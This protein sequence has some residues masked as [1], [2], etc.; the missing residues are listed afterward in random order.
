MAKVVTENFKVETTNELYGSFL[1]ENENAVESF[2]ESLEAYTAINNTGF[3]YYSY[4]VGATSTTFATS[5]NIHSEVIVVSG[6]TLLSPTSTPPDYTFTQSTGAIVLATGVTG[7]TVKI[8]GLNSTLSESTRDDITTL[9]RKEINQFLP[10]NNYYVM[11]SSIDKTNDILNSQFEKR[12][13]LRRVIFA[14]KIDVSNIKYMFNRIPWD[15]SGTTVYDAFDDI[16]DIETLNMFVT[17]PDGEQNEGPYKVFKCISNNNNSV[18]INKPSVNSIDPEYE[19]TLA[20]GYIWKYMFNIPVSEYA[21]YSTQA[22]LPYVEDVRVT[23]ATKEDISNIVIQNT[24]SGL[25]SGYLPGI[26]KIQ[27]VRIAPGDNRYEIDCT[28][29]E[30]SPRSGSGAYV[31]MYIRSDTGYLYDI[32]DSSVPNNDP[33]NRNLVITI[34]SEDINGNL[35]VLPDENGDTGIDVDRNATIVPKISITSSNDVETGINAVA[36]GS[37]DAN[38][39][40]EKVNFNEKGDGYKYATAKISLPLPLQQTYPDSSLAASLRVI[41]SPTGGHGKDPI[42]ELF[43]SRLAFITNFFTDSGSVIPDSGTYTKVGL[44]KDPSFSD[45]TFRSTMDNR[46]KI[47]ITG[48]T[49]PNVT[50]GQY[51]V[52]QQATQMIHARV[53]EVKQ[54]SGDWYIYC[55]DYTGDFNSTFT[56]GAT[57]SAKDTLVGATTETVTIN[58]SSGSITYGTYVPFSGDL[59]HF[60]DFAAISRDAD[61]KEKIKFVFDF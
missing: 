50:V 59:L 8:W 12:E 47:K 15:D 1:N 32:L 20:D 48:S 41:I 7:T 11:G 9:V 43:M 34:K 29:N 46:L 5:A 24:V 18:S 60:V 33:T 16:R 4:A 27:S 21:E 49:S 2:Q 54:E 57:L 13:F 19:V 40:L 42:S 55:V 3:K 26:L 58:S 45:A 23:G 35:I 52:E 56:L 38:G 14:K 61:R 22:S 53:H 17:V 25:F 37:L 28:T 39:T 44:V 10:E 36:W 30:T 51:L 6:N 31:G